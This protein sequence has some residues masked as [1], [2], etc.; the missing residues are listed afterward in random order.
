MEKQRVFKVEV[1][2][3][4]I[5]RQ[6][7]VVVHSNGTGSIHDMDYDPPL[8]LTFG[9][10]VTVRERGF[11]G[12]SRQE[13]AQNLGITE[14][15]LRQH[16]GDAASRF[17]SAYPKSE[18]I[19]ENDRDIALEGMAKM[20]FRRGLGNYFLAALRRKIDSEIPLD[21]RKRVRIF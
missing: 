16:E 6:V 20:L 17:R 11:W 3:A 9:Q 19:H 4:R 18:M 10:F 8:E 2:N 14:G 7:E 1:P 21:L 15:T 5:P 12:K 13:T